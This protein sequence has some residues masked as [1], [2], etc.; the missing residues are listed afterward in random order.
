MLQSSA[1][2]FLIKHL[3]MFLFFQT[4][5]GLYIEPSIFHDHSGQ[6]FDNFVLANKLNNIFDKYNYSRLMK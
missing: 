2:Y 5:M 6:Q 3:A 1:S 4:G